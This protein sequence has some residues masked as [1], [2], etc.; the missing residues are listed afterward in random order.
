MEEKRVLSLCR[1]DHPLL[2]EQYVSTAREAEKEL[3]DCA[4]SKIAFVRR[5]SQQD[6]R[7]R[8]AGGS[9]GGFAP[10]IAFFRRSSE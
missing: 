5:V 10:A 9:L 1:Q 7:S 3:V 6:S 4:E 8:Q 2:R